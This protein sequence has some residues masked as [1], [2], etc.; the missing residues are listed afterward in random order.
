MATV[1]PEQVVVCGQ[2]FSVK[3]V[4][5]DESPLSNGEALGRCN[6]D[7]GRMFISTRPDRQSPD[8]LRDTVLH[9]V[10]HAVVE[11][12]KLEG[13]EVDERLVSVLSTHL[14]DTLRRNPELVV[15]LTREN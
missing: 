1:I 13:T 10:V 7:T 9:E 3:Q 14:L 2:R 5:G 15:Y 6:I 12:N 4:F 11:L 8:Q